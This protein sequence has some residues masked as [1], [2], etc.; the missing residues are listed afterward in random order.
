MS[1]VPAFEYKNILEVI[2]NHA[3]ADQQIWL[4]GG[5]VRD[6]LTGRQ[7]H[8][9]DFAIQGDVKTLARRVANELNAAFYMLN[10]EHSTARV[11]WLTPKGKKLVLDFASLRAES[12]ESDLIA[13][14]FSINAI[15]ID[16]RNFSQ[17]IDPCH[18]VQDLNDKVIRACSDQSCSDDPIRILRGVRQ[19]VQFGF[20]I[21][22]KTIFWMKESVTDLRKISSERIRDELF[23][24]FAIRK[25]H[26]SMQILERLGALEVLFPFVPALKQEKQSQPHIY[27]VWEHTIATIQSLEELTLVLG[28]EYSE[29][30]SQKF[31]LGEAVLSLGRYRDIFGEFLEGT[32]HPDRSIKSLLFFSAFFHD[33][34]KPQCRTVDENGGIHYNGHEQTGCEIFQLYGQELALSNPEITWVNTIIK[35][36]MRIHQLAQ[37]DEPL[38]GKSIYRFFRDCGNGAIGLTL[39]SLA[40]TRATYGPALPAEIWKKELDT[41]RLIL[42]AYQNQFDTVIDPPRIMDG[43]ILKNDYELQPGPI[44]GELLEAVREEQVIGKITNRAEADLFV[45]RWLDEKGIHYGREI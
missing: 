1:Y 40:D 41:I 45:C 14:D 4:V 21:E 28:R 34:G 2:L 38:S 7:V 6:Y 35:N 13:R 11:I 31:W 36:H 8:D 10:D 43:H 19:A 26:L 37:M 24:I 27:S 25:P 39:F 20:K 17:C 33:V 3:D 18:G 29:A 30:D 32:L 12:L 9:L 16:L 42:D 15:A 44:F 22:S 5:A 23:Q